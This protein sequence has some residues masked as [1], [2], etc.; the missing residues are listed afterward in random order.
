MMSLLVLEN[1]LELGSPSL[2][3]A[4]GRERVAALGAEFRALVPEIGPARPAFLMRF[5]FARA[6]S[7][8]TGRRPVHE[9]I[10]VCA[11]RTELVDDGRGGA[12]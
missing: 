8:R 6:P 9:V 5:G 12:L 7:G 1:V 4:L 10:E 2:V 11:H 3:A